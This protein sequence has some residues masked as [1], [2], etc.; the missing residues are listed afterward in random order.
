[1]FTNSCA[2]RR[3]WYPWLFLT[4]SGQV[5]RRN[6]NATSTRRTQ[7]RCPT[8]TRARLTLP[9]QLPPTW[10]LSPIP[11]ATCTNATIIPMFPIP[12]YYPCTYCTCPPHPLVYKAKFFSLIKLISLGTLHSS[13][14]RGLSNVNTL[15]WFKRLLNKDSILLLYHEN[16]VGFLCKWSDRNACNL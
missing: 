4:I 16:S 7:C 6:S 3:L 12:V 13:H 8:W 14:F 9:N 11:K 15:L 2:S 10:A 5:W 1:M